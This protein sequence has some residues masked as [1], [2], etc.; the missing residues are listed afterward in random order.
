VTARSGLA[1]DR[2]KDF[3]SYLKSFLGIFWAQ[4]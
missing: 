2:W 4:R 1:K 3:K